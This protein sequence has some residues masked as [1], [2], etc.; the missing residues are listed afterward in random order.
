MQ[1]EN[2][3]TPESE[4]AADYFRCVLTDALNPLLDQVEYQD[5]A[6]KFDDVKESLRDITKLYKTGLNQTTPSSRSNWNDAANRCAYVFTYFMQHCHIVHYSLQQI[7]HNISTSWQNKNSL[8]ICSIGGGPGSDLVGLTRFLTDTDLFPPSLT[9]LVLDLYPN[10]KHTW[11]SIYNQLP[12][13]FDVTYGKCD[14]VDTTALRSDIL[15][16]IGKADMLTFVKSFSAVAA[17][18][19]KD[20]RKGSRLRSILHELKG[21]SFVLYIDNKHWDKSF[22]NNFA[23]PAGLEVV[24]DFCGKQT[25]PFGQHSHTIR[26]F[27]HHLDFRPMR[28]CD[29]TIWILYK[30][31]SV[32]SNVQSSKPSTMASGRS[33]SL[34]TIQQSRALPAHSILLNTGRSSQYVQPITR[35]APKLSASDSSYKFAY[36]T[37]QATPTVRPYRREDNVDEKRKLPQPK[38]A[39][40]DQTNEVYPPTRPSSISADVSYKQTHSVRKRS[41]WRS[42]WNRFKRCFCCTGTHT[43]DMD[44]W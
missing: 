44:W 9:C 4:A 19:R 26:E 43:N 31:K 29:V 2:N 16:S 21:G 24:F 17:F 39:S 32:R 41:N 38:L 42:A 22:L 27:S 30:K 3:H 25:L 6:S 11:E 40:R 1:N 5:R 36:P 10:W 18:L 8:V 14:L 12:E 33:H 37:A 35:A 13:T 34:T 15:H 28:N 20:P 7:Q 23:S